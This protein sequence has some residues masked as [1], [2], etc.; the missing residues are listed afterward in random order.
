MLQP[1]S[2]SWPGNSSLSWPSRLRIA[3]YRGIARITN[4]GKPPLAGVAFAAV[5]L[6]TV[7]VLS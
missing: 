2:L 4:Y 1:S 5:S 7:T 3:A 6:V